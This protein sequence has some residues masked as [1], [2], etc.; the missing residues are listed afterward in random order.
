[1]SKKRSVI[2]RDQFVPLL[3]AATDEQAGKLLKAMLKYQ[4]TGEAEVDEPLLGA[5]FEMVKEGID[6]DNK[7][8]EDTCERRRQAALKRW[9]NEQ[10]DDASACNSMQEHA[11]MDMDMDMDLQAP[12]VRSKESARARKEPRHRHGEYNHV[13]LTSEEYERLVKE[14]GEVK[15]AAAI[16]KVDEYCQTTGKTYKDYNLVIRKWGFDDRAPQGR[17]S[18]TVHF[19]TERT[20]VDY[21][22]I[23]RELIRKSRGTPA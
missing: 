17:A 5:I 15:V 9:E 18:P 13:M 1:M 10:E 14:F 4:A 21:N 8:Y 3:E 11:D 20:K 19:S 7:A 16:K 23:E 22:A 12:T 2:I 6:Q